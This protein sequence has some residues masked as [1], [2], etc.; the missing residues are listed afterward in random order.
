M[1]IGIMGAGAVGCFYGAMLARAGLS[2][3]M[4]GRPSFVVQSRAA[5]IRLEMAGS[6][7][8]YP[9]EAVSDPGALADVDVVLVCVKSGDSEAA[10][11]A[12]APVLKPEARVYSFQNG[13]DNAQRL[14][15]ILGRAVEPVAVYVAVDLAGPGH[16]RHHGRGDI[17]VQDKPENLAFADTMRAAGLAVAL[18]PDVMESLWQKL[19]VNCAYNALSAVSGLPYGA[20]MAVDGVRPLMI[21]VIEECLTVA[22][23]LGQKLDDPREKVLALAQQMPDQYSSTA[24]DLMRGRK[25]EIGHLNGFIVRMG[26]RLGIP[27][28]VNQALLTMVRLQE[29]R[30]QA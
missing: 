1:K 7:T 12:L 14:G 5:G 10:G 22:R 26:D 21:Q 11:A 15:D 16:V 27:T 9:V 2:P 3:V 17:V 8:R 19:I 28:P 20:V 29:A 13:V 24:Q 25:T 30:A 23:G 18:V 4:V 6:D